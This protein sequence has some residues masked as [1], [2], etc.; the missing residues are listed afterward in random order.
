MFLKSYMM[1]K[2]F[3]D[4]M[5]NKIQSNI[6]GANFQELG[7]DSLFLLC[8][9]DKNFNFNFI[10]YNNINFDKMMRKTKL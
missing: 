8:T 6:T 10:N 3:N 9:H 5:G 1:T 7:F 4:K 2:M